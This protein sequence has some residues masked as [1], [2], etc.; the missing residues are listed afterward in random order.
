[1]EI[2]VEVTR[3]EN[4]DY[5]GVSVGDTVRVEFEQYVAAVTA[6]E[7]AS[8][9]LEGCKAQAVS[10]RTFA[11]ARGVLDGK[12]ISDSSSSAQAYRARRYDKKLYPVPIQAARE[13]EGQILTFGGKAISA[14]YSA[15]NGGRTVSSAERWGGAR[16]YLIA[17]DDPWDAA[18]GSGR[19]G[20]GVGMSQRGARYAAGLGIS[21]R[22]ILAF[23]Y[24]GAALCSGYGKVVMKVM[25]ESSE[26]VVALARERIGQPYVFGA[27]GEDC[28]PAN[29]KRRNRADYPNIVGKCQA[30][31]GKK[32]TCAGC[33]YNGSQI[34]DCR[35][36]TYWLLKQVGISISTVG[37]TTQYN[38]SKDWAER[39][40]TA[41]MPD[42]VC[43][44]FK[45]VGSKMSHTGMHIGGGRIIHC[46]GEVKECVIDKSWTHYAIPKYL[47]SSEELEEAGGILVSSILKTGSK[48]DAVRSLQ[49]DLT[50]LGFGCGDIDGKFGTK[51]AA[52]VKAFQKAY[53]LS[54]DGVAGTVTQTAIANA[55]AGVS[56]QPEPSPDPNDE[57]TVSVRLSALEEAVARLAQAAGIEL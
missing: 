10:A 15:S 56:A 38:T 45:K 25:N 52:A 30:L 12:A 37:A 17:Q 22:E 7:L 19:S 35:G 26:K 55:L 41:S 53:G 29:R 6:S 20:H 18:A 8:G 40:E 9:G 42:L 34:Y 24:P 43:C 36:F 4:A 32:S 21:Y 57:K 13:T 47:Y 44:V 27:L 31:S 14:V 50:K 11:V 49:E 33:K 39:G 16:P 28:T 54:V 51:T 46:S 1:M 2:I 3:Q 5:F 23:Y 48:G